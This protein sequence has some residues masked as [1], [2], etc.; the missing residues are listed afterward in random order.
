[1]PAFELDNYDSIKKEDK[2]SWQPMFIDFSNK[3]S[4]KFFRLFHNLLGNNI[5]ELV[6]DVV[7]RSMSAPTFFPR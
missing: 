4:K 1:M 2:R 7:L 5:K 6:S 3:N